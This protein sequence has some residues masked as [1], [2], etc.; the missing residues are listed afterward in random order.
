MPNHT[1]GSD[2]MST[3]QQKGVQIRRVHGQK[4]VAGIVV[5]AVGERLVRDILEENESLFYQKMLICLLLKISV[6]ALR[7]LVEAII[8]PF[9]TSSPLCK[10]LGQFTAQL[11]LILTLI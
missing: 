7:C 4:L 10:K 6:S 11:F 3:H 2:T 9:G 1:G 8:F 5:P